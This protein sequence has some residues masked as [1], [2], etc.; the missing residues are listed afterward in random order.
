MRRPWLNRLILPVGVLLAYF[1]VPVDAQ[2]APAGVLIGAVIAVVG[3]AGVA[4]VVADEV[5]RAERRLRPV[6]LLLALELV[7]VIFALVYFV[8]ATRSPVEFSGLHTRLDA[9]YFSLTT[10]ATVGYGDVSAAGQL[11]RLIVSV[12]LVFNLAFVAA[13]VG[14]FQGSLRDGRGKPTATGTDGPG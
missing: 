3:L 4:W 12:Q 8:L 2:N 9:L 7:V 6:H 13:L 5:Q 1:L 14:L 11:A 10:V